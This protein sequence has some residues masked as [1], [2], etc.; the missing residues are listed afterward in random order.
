MLSKEFRKLLSLIIIFVPILL[1]NFQ[2]NNLKI[3]AKNYL[4]TTQIFHPLQ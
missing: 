2:I 1:I 4:L 3:E